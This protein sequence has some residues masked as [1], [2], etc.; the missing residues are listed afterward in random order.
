MSR[1]LAFYTEVLGLTVTD[2]D[3]RLG[4]WFLSARPDTEHHE[5]LL[6]EGGTRRS[7]SNSSSRCRSGARASRTSSASTG[8]S[9][10]A[11]SGST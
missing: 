3:E 1:Q 5:L 9:G 10:S 4:I 6:A 7:A 11:T 2:H 8:V